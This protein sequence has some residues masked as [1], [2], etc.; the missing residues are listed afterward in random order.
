MWDGRAST[1][2]YFLNPLTLGGEAPEP[3]II[4]RMGCYLIKD[5]PQQHSRGH[6]EIVRYSII[7]FEIFHLHHACFFFPFPQCAVL[8][9]DVCWLIG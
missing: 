6:S 1:N 3:S 7:E 5:C 8:L 9:N 2:L 4:S